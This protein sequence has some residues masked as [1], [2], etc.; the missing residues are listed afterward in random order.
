MCVS[1]RC[2]AYISFVHTYIYA[3]RMG[4][5]NTPLRVCILALAS[6]VLSD[7]AVSLKEDATLSLV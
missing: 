2:M 6:T 5:S 7:L 1:F 4:E 3:V